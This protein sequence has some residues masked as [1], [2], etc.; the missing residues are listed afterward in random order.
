MNPKAEARPIVR[1]ADLDDARELARLRWDF[2]LDDSQSPEEDFETFAESLGDFLAKGMRQG[3]VAVFV[4]DVGEKLVANLWVEVVDKV[5]R[6]YRSTSAWGY[7][8]NVYTE[9]SFRD[10]GLGTKILEA[11]IRWAQ[12]K[13]LELLIV[14]PSERSVEFYRRAGFSQNPMLLELGLE[15][16][17]PSRRIWV[18]DYDPNWPEM[19]ETEKGHIL[20]AI[21]AQVVA[22]EH[23]GSTAVP[24]LGAKPTIDI[25]VGLKRLPDFKRCI[26]PLEEIGYEH[27]PWAEDADLLQR[28]YFRKN[29]DGE[30]THHLHMTEVGSQFFRKHLLFRDYLRAH[31]D[32]AAEYYDLKEQLATDFEFE[33]IGY[34]EAKTEFIE[35]T[36]RNAGWAG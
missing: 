35:G 23:V 4:G 3:R 31:P 32:T 5:P 27:A 11:A 15:T 14:W 19:Y 13:K 24:G 21:G 6:P 18:T 36:L 20:S 26:L 12:L 8:T 9:A 17:G 34:T 2:T 16:P 1:L 25:M 33:P 10:S 30:R 29:T 7:V 22:I 28:R